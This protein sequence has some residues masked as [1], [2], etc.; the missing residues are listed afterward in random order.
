MS[1]LWINCSLQGSWF[2]VKSCNNEDVNLLFWWEPCYFPMQSTVGTLELVPS[3]LGHALWMATWA[4][5]SCS[6]S[7]LFDKT[8]SIPISNTTIYRGVVR[9]RHRG[10][11][12]NLAT[13]LLV[14]KFSAT[15]ISVRDF[16]NTEFSHQEIST[17]DILSQVWESLTQIR[18]DYNDCASTII[19]S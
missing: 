8:I 6:E 5:Y 3:Y 18:L 15:E 2:H 1:L 12:L 13:G 16:S 19:P 14:W 4:K 11:C 10:T 9:G 7:V 17:N